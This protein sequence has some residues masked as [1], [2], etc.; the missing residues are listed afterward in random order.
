MYRTTLHALVQVLAQMPQTLPALTDWLVN[1]K[2]TDQ[3]QSLVLR[4][5][6]YLTLFQPATFSMQHVYHGTVCALAK[7]IKGR[8]TVLGCGRVPH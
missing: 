8:H 2:L 1:F 7:V 4:R 3:M 6:S 5:Q